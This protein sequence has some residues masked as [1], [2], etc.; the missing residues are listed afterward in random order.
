MFSVVNIIIASANDGNLFFGDP[1][2]FPLPKSALLSKVTN[3]Y[4][5]GNILCMERLDIP[6]QYIPG[7]DNV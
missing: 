7:N 6:Q 1:Y 5:N 3:R 2:E 4:R